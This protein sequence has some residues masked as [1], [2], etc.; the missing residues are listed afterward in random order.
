MTSVL[1]S[2]DERLSVNL[3]ERKQQH[4]YRERQTIEAYGDACYVTVA[5]ES[6]VNFCSNDYLGLSQ[7]PYLIKAFQNA[8]NE[9]GVGSGASHL[10]CGHSYYHHQLEEAL[11]EF[12]GRDRAVVFS[13]GYMANL[14]VITTLLAKGDILLQDRLNHA[15]LL[16]AGRL[17]GAKFQ[18]YQHNDMA[19][20]EQ[21]LT[22]TNALNKLIVA[23]AVFSMDGDVAL[24]PEICQLAKHHAAD[25]MID[26][27]HGFGV[28]GHKGAGTASHFN[29]SQDDV[30]VYMATLGKAVGGFGAF[31]AGSEALIESLIQFARPYIYTTALPP[32]V[33]A[34]NLAALKV[35]HEDDFRR[36]HLQAL[37]KH[38]KAGAKAYDLPIM[39]SDTAIQPLL[40]NDSKLALTVSERLKL[41]GFWVGAIRPPTV[42][43]D[44][45]RL[46]ITLSAE[47]SVQQVDQ[48][49][50]AL[51]EALL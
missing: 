17:S 10:V 39:P 26:D 49:L 40:V 14:G 3:L 22:N 28:L 19:Y 11:A 15:S 46:R 2:F 35:I 12:T 21:R 4:L 41:K 6:F 37:I 9:Y 1:S 5:G 34:A 45:A 20:L 25:V 23:D 51:K 44:S 43:A 42:P 47:H 13:T 30:P 27:A 50:D 31:V 29:L 24:L 36:E 38:F 18:R 16:D 7:H 48:L 32:A 8:S 33:A